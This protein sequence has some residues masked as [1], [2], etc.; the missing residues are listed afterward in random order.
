MTQKNGSYC[1]DYPHP[2]VTVDLV[3]L[4]REIGVDYV[5]LVKRGKEP[6]EGQWALPGGFLNE[7]ESPSNAAKREALEETGFKTNCEPRLIGIYAD[8]GRDPRGW[9]ISIAFRASV[10][11]RNTV[12]GADDAK[13][14]AWVKVDDLVG[15]PLAFDHAKILQQALEQWRKGK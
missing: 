3:V 12:K 10:P 4:A 2:A 8:K 15:V 6:Y 1:Y 14:A 13:E 9:V 5:L 7:G 11:N